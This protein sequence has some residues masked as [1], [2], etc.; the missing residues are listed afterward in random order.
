MSRLEPPVAVREICRALQ[1]AGFEAWCVGGAVRDALLGIETLDWDI[2]TS[3]RPEEVQRLFRRTIP[4]GIQFGT[5]GVLDREGVLHEVTTFRHDVETDGRHAVV[6]FGASLDEDLARRDFTI[7]AI[8]VQAETLAIRDPFDGRGDLARGVVRCVGIAAARMEEDRLRALRAIRFAGRFAFAIDAET[9]A[10]ICAS[11]PFLTRLSME[12]VKQELDKIMEQ[13]ERPSGS[14]ERYRE[15]G[16][17]AALIP[18]LADAPALR[19]RTIDRLARPARVR[20]PARR[21]LRLAAL[22]AEPGQAAPAALERTLKGLRFSNEE[23]ALTRSVAAAVAALPSMAV[24][25]EQFSAEVTLRRFVATVG[26]LQVPLV[27]RVLWARAAAELAAADADAAVLHAARQTGIRL[28]RRAMRITW[29]DPITL[30]DLAI[31]GDDLRGVGIRNGPEVGA[32]L[33]RLLELVLEDPSRNT[34]ESL[35][36]AASD[37]Q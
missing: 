18:A 3:A 13:V 1:G 15:A 10:A 29:R 32:T 36:A 26:R 28:Y 16:V 19:F 2:A 34:R 25:T 7:N 6:R 12:R 33:K 27:A 21:A 35:L 22:F 30:G 11:A 31:D 37:R 17:F 5:V 9:W 20:R 8:A 4:V 23:V 24:V 14:L